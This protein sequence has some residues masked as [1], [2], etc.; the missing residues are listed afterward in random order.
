MV[1]CGVFRVILAICF[2]ALPIAAQNWISVGVKGGNPLTN[3][4][5]DRTDYVSI[6]I[7][8]APLSS[9]SES[10]RT[11]SGSRSFVLGPTIEIALPFG[12]SAEMDGLYRPLNL[13][14][15]QSTQLPNVVFSNLVLNGPVLSNR[16][17]SWE[18]PLVAKYRLPL[19]RMKPY[20]EAGPSFRATSG[21]PA[22]HMSGKGFT[23]GVGIESMVGR[24][25]I[26]PEVRYTRWGADGTYNTIYH[27]VSRQSQIE[28]LAGLTPQS[29]IQRTPQTL[30]GWRKYLSVGVKGGLPFTTAF[31]NDGFGRVT[32]PTVRCGD[33]STSNCTVGG[34]ATVQTYKASRNYLVVP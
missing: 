29:G 27:A 4:F 19:P 6:R 1:L 33:F 7:P 13:K 15:Q 22:Q 16:I 3:P 9:S 21:S 18:F 8:F 28:L 30:S 31:L 34:D 14:T 10:I 12:L 2:C 23:V 25:R 11:F 17:D 5:A 32:F 24:F 20:L 26:S